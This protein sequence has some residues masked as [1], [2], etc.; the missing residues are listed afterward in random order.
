MEGSCSAEADAIVTGDKRMLK[1]KEY[2]GVRI[3]NLKEY[4][5]A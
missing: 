1:L 5:V 4:L 3:I 2:K